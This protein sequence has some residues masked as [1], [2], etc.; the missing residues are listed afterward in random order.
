M[1]SKSQIPNSKVRIFVSLLSSSLYLQRH[2]TL[3]P[4]RS[5]FGV[6]SCNIDLS[7]TSLNFSDIDLSLA[8]L[9]VPS[10]IYLSLSRHSLLS[11]VHGIVIYDFFPLLKSPSLSPF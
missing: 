10:T 1:N 6:A 8:L 4:P 7:L 2:S 11:E 3:L 9:V 5:L